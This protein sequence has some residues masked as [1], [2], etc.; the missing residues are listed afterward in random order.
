MKVCILGNGLTSLTLAKALVNQNI[1]V[2]IFA[3]NKVQKLS[4]L[5]TIGISKSNIKFFNQKII[6]IE[7]ILWKLKKIEIFTDNLKDEKL[8][9]FEDDSEQLFSI[10]RNYELHQILS[11]NLAKSK[12]F[13]QKLIN[14]KQSVLIDNY[15]LIVN[16]EYGHP[17]TKKYFSK[18]IEKTY[19]SFAYTTIIKHKKILNNV[20]TQIFTKIGPLAFLP[21][22]NVETSIVY[23]VHSSNKKN[24][25]NIKEL[26]Q[27]YN[28]KYKIKHMGNI[29]SFELKS[30]SLRSY[31]HDNILAF[32]DLLHRI[33]P[34]AGQ[35]FNMII[36][37]IRMLTNII[38]DKID[39]GLPLDSLVN[40]EFEK[41]TKHKNF[42]FSN[43]I[44]LIH[45]FFNIERKTKNN[46]LSK[47]VQFLG[48]NKLVNK[49]LTKYADSGTII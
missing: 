41:N 26:I 28:S 14:N 43:G 36:R 20:A 47:S 16:C 25:E 12:F 29:E 37:D 38:K 39:L 48:K 1:H 17:F 31:Y 34:L 35:G 15:E 21:I 42:I 4:K 23:S 46:I 10:L 13:N 45:S 6:N 5:R 33:H 49:A 40:E 30:F 27:G 19:N 18:K 32:G 8:I 11:N 22:S 2:D 3:Q 44:N 24:K 9:N 7:K